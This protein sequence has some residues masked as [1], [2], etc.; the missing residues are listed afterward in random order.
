MKKREMKKRI[1]DGFSELAPDIFEN[2]LEAAEEL[3]CFQVDAGQL[4]EQNNEKRILAQEHGRQERTSFWFGKLFT[5]RF[6]RY[7]L[8]M[9]ACL[10]MICLCIFSVREKSQN[11][12]YM[13]LDINPSIQVEMNRANQVKRLRGLNQDGKD[14]VKE[15]KWKKEEPVQELLDVLLQDV[16]EKS[17]LGE[18]GGILVT[19]SAPDKDICEKL[20]HSLGEGIDRKLTELKV[21]GVMTAF[22]QA[23]ADHAKQGRKILEAE[24][25]QSCGM[26][27]EEV[28]Q[29]SVMELIQYCQDYTSVELKLSEVSAKE[30]EAQ[31]QQKQEDKVPKKTETLADEDKDS[32]KPKDQ[33][34]EDQKS[35]APKL[36]DQKPSIEEEPDL[37]PEEDGQS[38]EQPPLDGE[39]SV[40]EEEEQ[41]EE[42]QPPAEEVL[43]EGVVPE[44]QPPSAGEALSGGAINPEDENSQTGTPQEGSEQNKPDQGSKEDEESDQEDGPDMNGGS[45]G[46]EEENEPIQ[47]VTP[48]QS[49]IEKDS[50]E[51][52]NEKDEDK[53]DRDKNGYQ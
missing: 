3:V 52:Q 23:K 24:L 33:K 11:V 14:V 49:G 20:E 29:M 35:K 44:E 43:P 10:A 13:V 22:Q 30:R 32:Q 12:V 15:L 21:P 42:Q 48:G 9:C 28:E 6:P 16:V 50:V 38:E 19:L 41:P 4:T 8:S 40:P 36:E 7:V 25:E 37:P 34:S 5:E 53:K 26:K 31:V 46:S 39:P 2:V 45:Q 17:Y 47:M 1:E 18:N 27:Q 51:D